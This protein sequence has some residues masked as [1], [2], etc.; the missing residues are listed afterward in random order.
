[1]H[2]ERRIPPQGKSREGQCKTMS[3]SQAVNDED[4]CLMW[5][6]TRVSELELCMLPAV[7]KGAK[8]V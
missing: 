1:M 3:V 4:T 2:A 8:F 5:K 7:G 6:V